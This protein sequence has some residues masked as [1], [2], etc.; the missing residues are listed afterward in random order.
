METE[1]SQKTT[2]EKIL[3]LVSDFESESRSLLHTVISAMEN[4]LKV[5]ERTSEELKRGIDGDGG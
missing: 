4:D 1:S 5:L 3:Q 2:M